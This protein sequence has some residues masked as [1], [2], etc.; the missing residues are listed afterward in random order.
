MAMAKLVL[1]LLTT[2]ILVP[3][4]D[5]Q[6]RTDFVRLQVGSGSGECHDASLS[7]GHQNR[8]LGLDHRRPG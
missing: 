4:F 1:Q 3:S 2:A 8:T 7:V 5:R 6:E